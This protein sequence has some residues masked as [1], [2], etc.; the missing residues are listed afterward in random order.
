MVIYMSVMIYGKNPAEEIINS[1]KKIIRAFVQKETNEGIL[2]RGFT[3]HDRLRNWDKV[4][5]TSRIE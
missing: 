3:I 5:F 1:K 2:N 4:S